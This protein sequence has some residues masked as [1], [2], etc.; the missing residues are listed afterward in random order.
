ML[1]LKSSALTILTFDTSWEKPVAFH[2]YLRDHPY[3]TSA[4]GLVGWMGGL[5]WSRLCTVLSNWKIDGS[6]KIFWLFRSKSLWK[7]KKIFL[8]K[9]D[10]EHSSISRDILLCS[11]SI[12][13]FGKRGGE[14]LWCPIEFCIFPNL[15]SVYKVNSMIYMALSLLILLEKL[16]KL[17]KLKRTLKVC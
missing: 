7:S 9:I 14:Y 16:C 6:H 2:I 15:I 11:V 17:G 8:L 4:K 13:W 10:T 3:I 5:G 1:I 12:K